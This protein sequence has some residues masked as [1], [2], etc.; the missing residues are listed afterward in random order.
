MYEA[1]EKGRDG[2]IVFDDALQKRVEQNLEV[3]QLLH[4]ALANNEISLVYQPQVDGHSNIIGAETLVRWNN[5]KLGEIGPAVFIPIAEQTGSIIEIGRFIMETAF[6]TLAEWEQHGIHVQQF[7]INVSMRQ[8]FYYG[9]IDDVFLLCEKYLSEE[10]RK[11]VIFE[12]T[13]SIIAED[14]DKV[15]FIMEEIKKL[16]IRFSMDDF[17]TGYSSL[18]YMERL[19]IDEIKIDR[20][21]ISELTVETNDNDNVMVR[22]ILYMAKH[23]DLKVVAEGVETEEQFN[24]L[25]KNNCDIYQGYYFSRPLSDNDFRE[26]HLNHSTI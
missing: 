7:S 16:G 18:S 21:F 19:P 6:R 20:S 5:K 17:G 13:E 8:F 2:I 1:K 4:F 14:V 3:E 10:T 25:Q 9:F 15:V 11:T 26:H 23:F 24:I 22:S 12:V